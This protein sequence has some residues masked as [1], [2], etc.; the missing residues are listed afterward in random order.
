MPQTNL[1]KARENAKSIGVTVKSSTIKNK[2]LDV[3][4]NGEKIAS[5]GDIHYGDFLTTGDE[6]K[7]ENYLKRHQKTRTKV[8]S[9]SYYAAK[10][11]WSA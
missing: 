1:T 8:G 11:L 3:F 7:R 2:K 10:I 5:I 4:K 9:P 6:K